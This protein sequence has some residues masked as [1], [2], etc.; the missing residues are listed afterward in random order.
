MDEAEE[1]PTQP[2][3][4]SNMSL[5]DIQPS[6]VVATYCSLIPVSLLLNDRKQEFSEKVSNL[7]RDEA[8]IPEFSDRISDPSEV[9]TEA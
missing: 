6:L 4:A 1:S 5:S 3:P 8:F 9:E 7:V 2:L